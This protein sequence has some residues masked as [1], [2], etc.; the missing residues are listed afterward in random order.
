MFVLLF[1]SFSSW[2]HDD[3]G[4]QYLWPQ[5][6]DKRAESGITVRECGQTPWGAIAP[7]HHAAPS[8][9]TAPRSTGAARALRI[10]TRERRQSSRVAFRDLH[11]GY[12]GFAFPSNRP[13]SDTEPLG[14]LGG[15]SIRGVRDDVA[16][17]SLL[18][19]RI[20]PVANSVGS[21]L[22]SSRL[23]CPTW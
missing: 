18:T 20:C 21:L 10:S 1:G 17:L 3:R 15:I 13:V 22:Y 23:R 12:V 14:E 9:R 7:A 5:P 16:I 4:L 11:R 19:K 8:L 6:S 2:V